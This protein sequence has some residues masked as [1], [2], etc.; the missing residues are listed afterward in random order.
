MNKIGLNNPDIIKQGS[1]VYG[2]MIANKINEI[3]AWINAHD[4]GVDESMHM[5]NENYVRKP[6][7]VREAQ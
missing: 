6:P 1:Y 4:K 7:T 2:D 3:V 5:E